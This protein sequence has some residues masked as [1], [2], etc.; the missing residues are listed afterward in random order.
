MD[1]LRDCGLL[2]K[3]FRGAIHGVGMGTIRYRKLN[4]E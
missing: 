4:D 2:L 1:H 3:D